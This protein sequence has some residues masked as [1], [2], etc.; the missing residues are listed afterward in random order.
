MRQMIGEKPST[1]CLP[2]PLDLEASAT[3]SQM[4]ARRFSHLVSS[5][6]AAD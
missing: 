6:T 4:R 2:A 3:L 1:F 5:T